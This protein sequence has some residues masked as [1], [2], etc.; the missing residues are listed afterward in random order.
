MKKE[1]EVT[2]RNLQDWDR[3][4]SKR[5]GVEFSEEEL[6]QMCILKLIEEVGE[7]A[8][9]LYER[10]WK[11]VQAE[12]CDVITFVVK[13]ANVAEDFHGE[14]EL[15]KVFRKKIEYSEARQF[16]RKTGKFSKPG[17]YEFK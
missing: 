16:D 7:M 2:I 13:I 5:K 11:T 15:S 10:D 6:I 3:D 8:K 1:K 9:A 14:E 4:F 12:I 17:G